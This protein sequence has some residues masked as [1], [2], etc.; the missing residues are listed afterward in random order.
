MFALGELG[1]RF[2]VFVCDFQNVALSTIE[3]FV[4]WLT[5]NGAALHY[6]YNSVYNICVVR[7]NAKHPHTTHK[8]Y[9]PT[10]ASSF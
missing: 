4:V 9:V 10:T 3:L 7:G 2:M 5:C 6:P 8:D 1:S